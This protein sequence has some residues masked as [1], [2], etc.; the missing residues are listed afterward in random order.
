MED[1]LSDNIEMY[2]VKF[3]EHFITEL[4]I[5]NEVRFELGENI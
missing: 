5:V 2:K 1:N 3:I 4:S